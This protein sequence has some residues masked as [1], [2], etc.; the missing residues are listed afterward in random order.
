MRPV[1]RR[2]RRDCRRTWRWTI[3]CGKEPFRRKRLSAG[4]HAM[5]NAFP[6]RQ[7]S[8]PGRDPDDPSR[9]YAGTTPPGSSHMEG[10]PLSVHYRS[11]RAGAGCTAAA[12]Q[13]RSGRTRSGCQP[14]RKERA[15]QLFRRAPRLLP[16]WLLQLKKTEQRS[17]I[18]GRTGPVPIAHSPDPCLFPNL[19]EQINQR[20]QGQRKRIR[21]IRRFNGG[22]VG[23]GNLHGS[24]IVSGHRDCA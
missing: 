6:A 14:F 11:G 7:R 24:S 4:S 13:A 9:P 12:G 22:M 23:C 18:H 1:K 21:L 10:R 5:K 8:F 2:R 17:S 15:G 16:R 3:R 19:C 20:I